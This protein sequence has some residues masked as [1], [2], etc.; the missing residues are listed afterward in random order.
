MAM[1]VTIL[2]C[3]WMNGH[4]ARVK[5]ARRSDVLRKRQVR[6]A[7]VYVLGTCTS[8][9]L[10]WTGRQVEGLAD[11]HIRTF[12]LRTLRGYEEGDKEGGDALPDK[13]AGTGEVLAYNAMARM[14]HRG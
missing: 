12:Y 10:G 2:A 4:V 1:D 11:V 8:W 9:P 7:R 13:C 5:E 14:V 3:S 6:E